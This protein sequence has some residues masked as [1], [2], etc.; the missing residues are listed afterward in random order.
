MDNETRKLIWDSLLAADYRARYFGDLAG[1]LARV[2]RWF[3]IASL[4]LSSSAVAALLVGAPKE[5]TTAA[6]LIV[7]LLSATQLV[8]KFGERASDAADLTV[9]WLAI[10][11]DL[12]ALWAR[13]DLDSEAARAAWAEI[14]ARHAQ[15]DKRAA[16]EFRYWRGLARRAWREML[17]ARGL[18]EAA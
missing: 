15:D 11:R 2:E 16:K 9:A 12:Q 1:Y 8:Q 10:Q 4:V 3:T 17:A 14:E 7:A 13:Q 6:V 5:L 18:P